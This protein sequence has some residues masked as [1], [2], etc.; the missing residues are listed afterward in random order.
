M[1]AMNTGKLI[2]KPSSKSKH[3]IPTAMSAPFLLGIP[4]ISYQMQ[5]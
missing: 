1:T 5:E 3:A 2:A 4:D